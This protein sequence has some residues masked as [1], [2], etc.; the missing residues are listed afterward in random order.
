M[1]AQFSMCLAD[2]A[3]DQHQFA[4]MEMIGVEARAAIDQAVEPQGCAVGVGV[5]LE[6]DFDADVV[7]AVAVIGMGRQAA[8]R[9]EEYRADGGAGAAGQS[10]PSASHVPVLHFPALPA[11][12]GAIL[13]A[14]R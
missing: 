10:R 12:V 4:Q 6:G 8:E 3:C 11:T 7:A 2:G 14:R 5:L 1:H 13:H 9:H